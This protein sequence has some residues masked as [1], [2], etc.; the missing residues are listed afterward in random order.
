MN[1]EPSNGLKPFRRGSFA[2]AAKF[3]TPIWGAALY[4]CATAW[5]RD[6]TVGGYPCT[7]ALCL[8]QLLVPAAGASAADVAEA[9]QAA[10]QL[11][12]N[13]LE[14]RLGDAKKEQ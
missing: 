13:Q 5:P 8:Q 4:N 2:Q 3:S 9:S 10:M 14:L 7:V 1:K 6:A 11:Q 12:V